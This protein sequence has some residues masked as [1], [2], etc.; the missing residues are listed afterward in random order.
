MCSVF[1]LIYNLSSTL[2]YI[3]FL[4]LNSKKYI[5]TVFLVIFN[6]NSKFFF[7]KNGMN[8]NLTNFTSKQSY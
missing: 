8:L 3:I 6:K 7:L 1:I 5:S 2:E 4:G